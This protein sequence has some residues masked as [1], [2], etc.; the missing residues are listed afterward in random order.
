MLSTRVCATHS[1]VAKT[2]RKRKVAKWFMAMD[3]T[4]SKVVWRPPG[5]YADPVQHRRDPCQPHRALDER[6]GAHRPAGRFGRGAGAPARPVALPQ[7][8]RAQWAG[9]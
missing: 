8:T 3:L 6:R 2:S 5:S 9:R 1:V 7:A 4:R